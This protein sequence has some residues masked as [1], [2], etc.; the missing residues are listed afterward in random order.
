[1]KI[2]IPYSII[3]EMDEEEINQ[4]LGAE[5]AIEEYIHEKQNG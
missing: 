3:M 5:A 2:G 4:L 1:L